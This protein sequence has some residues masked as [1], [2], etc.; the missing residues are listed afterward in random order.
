MSIIDFEAEREKIIQMLRE[1]LEAEKS[2]DLKGSI[3]GYDEDCYILA[4]GAKLMKGLDDIQ[5]FLTSFLPSIIDI[6]SEAIDVQF[7]E[8]GDMAYLVASSRMVMKH[9][10]STHE[11]VGKFLS[12]LRKKSG[13][14]K[15]VAMCS[16][17][18]S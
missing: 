6:E 10:G 2:G 15:A 4:P 12:F 13:E 5:M 11:D 9:E 18:D 1:G 8:K 3:R 7:S 16:N 17:S 14:W